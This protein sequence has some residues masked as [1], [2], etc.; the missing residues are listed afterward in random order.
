MDTFEEGREVTGSMV[1]E[2]GMVALL[3]KS[4]I[5]QQIA[6][7]HQFPRSIKTFRNEA[8]QLVTLSEHVAEECFY[9]LPRDGKVIEGPTA[10]FAEIIASS[11]GNCRAGARVVSDQ[12]EFVTAQ[13]GFHDL[14]KNVAITF[15]VQRR[16]VDKNGKRYKTDM[17]GVTGNAAASVALRNA[18]LKGVPKALWSDLYTAARRCAIGDVK[19]LA[20][21]RANAIKEFAIF[22]VSEAQVLK[23]LGRAGVEDI[24]IDDLVILM[25][26][27]TAIK[28][29]DTTPEAAFAGS[30][31]ERAPVAESAPRKSAAK[32]APD[33]VQQAQAAAQA[34]QQPG[35]LSNDPPKAN[36]G[37]AALNKTQPKD[38]APAGGDEPLPEKVLKVLRVKIKQAAITDLDFKAKWDK[39]LCTEDGF[40]NF[41]T[42]EL[43]ALEAWIESKRGG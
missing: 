2:S 18:I 30:E 25:G 22:G 19:S 37:E 29:G 13:G 16:I 23:L 11:W 7:A 9:A 41:T 38:E 32:P 3:N 42:A 28:D 40:P 35:G 34:Q 14:Q 43:P 6:T 20:T 8:L 1:A 10:R 36:G 5:D 12:G 21:K 31:P 27:R 4:E 26:V 39:T 24:T 15:E 33:P 17:I